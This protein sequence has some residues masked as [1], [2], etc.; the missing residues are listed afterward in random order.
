MAGHDDE[1]GI[2]RVAHFRKIATGEAAASDSYA[3]IPIFAHR[4]LHDFAASFM[5]E[6]GLIAPGGVA[7]DIACGAGAMSQRLADMGMLVTGLDALPENFAATSPIASVTGTDLNGRFHE[8]FEGWA[9][10]AVAMEIIEHVESP[11]AF[12]RSCFAC[13]KPGGALVLTMPNVDSSYAIASLALKGCFARFDD[14][15]LRNDGHIMPICR[16]QFLAA[17]TDAGFAVE[18]EA[19]HGRD[20]VSPRAWPKFWALLSALRFLRRAGETREASI[21]AYLLRRPA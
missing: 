3:G 18:A 12:L 15:Y 9:N 2:A 11:R 5:R 21:S 14:N 8:G 6:R 7:I 13:L 4:G 10:L 1:G 16:H 19:G 20:E 17:A